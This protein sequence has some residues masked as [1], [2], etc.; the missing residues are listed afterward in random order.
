MANYN[1]SYTYGD[2]PEGEDRKATTPVDYFGI[3]NAFGLSDMHGNVYQWCEDVWHENYGG[4]PTD[5]SAR[6]KGG[7]QRWRVLRGGSWGG[8]P[9]N[10]RSASR[11]RFNPDNVNLNGFR[12]VC[13]APR[14]V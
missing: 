1:G 8:N 4:A 13:S 2:G 7:N 3:G 9:R 6:I 10:C 5:G 12:V 11:C 14:T